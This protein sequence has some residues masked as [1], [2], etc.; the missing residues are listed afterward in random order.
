MEHSW[1]THMLE[2]E[3]GPASCNVDIAYASEVADASRPMCTYVVVPFKDAG[4]YGIG[5]EAER[6]H[7]GE[8][9]DAIQEAVSDSGAVMVATIRSGGMLA[10]M[11]YGDDA[12][13]SIIAEVA[14]KIC[15][16][17]TIEVDSQE[18]PM[19]SQ[20]A[21]ILPDEEAVQ[22]AADAGLIQHLESLG[23]T[24]AT[25]R[26]VDHS[27]FL[28]TQEA[29]D[30]FAATIAGLGFEVTDRGTDEI[31]DE[32]DQGDAPA[33]FVQ[34]TRTHPI[35]LETISVIREQLT[36]LVEPHGGEYDGW[37]TPLVK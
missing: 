29:A 35:D 8:F 13:A 36:E 12:A 28:P 15:I 21:D 5:D 19:W 4:E 25:P 32:G 22:L 9:E 37:Q 31:D 10:M 2:S 14:P 26:P 33:Y 34:V 23:D 20:Y 30:E 27:V 3:E 6:E 18:D 17:Y 11:F 7:M 16:G 24:I 1:V